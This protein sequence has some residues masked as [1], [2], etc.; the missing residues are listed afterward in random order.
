[1]KKENLARFL[2]VFFI[3]IA[4]AIPVV[5]RL[6]TSKDRENT[7]ELHARVF[8]NGSW[9]TDR[10]EAVVGEPVHLRMT[11]E[12]VVHGFAVGGYTLTPIKILPG[13]FVETTLT[14]EKPGEY[15]FFCT[16]WCGPNHTR[17][18]GTIVVT[19]A[20]TPGGN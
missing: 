2:V 13:E 6:V 19:T 15:T 1:M 10:I 8:E 12:D 16:R 20:I 7:T 3:I 4:V 9:S 14:F 18:R 11:S 5:G 17:M